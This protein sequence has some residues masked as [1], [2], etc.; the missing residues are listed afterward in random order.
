MIAYIH[1]TF[2]QRLYI[3]VQ[4][5]VPQPVIKSLLQIVGNR[6]RFE[7]TRLVAMV[8]M[9]FKADSII[10]GAKEG[11]KCRLNVEYMKLATVLGTEIGHIVGFLVAAL[12]SRRWKTVEK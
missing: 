2:V 11:G 7:V 1:T 9:E 3:F 4:K 6:E 10:R 5:P 12:I 8:S